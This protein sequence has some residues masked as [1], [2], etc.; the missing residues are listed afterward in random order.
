MPSRP[1]TPLPRILVVDDEE[2]MRAVMELR[3]GEW[4]FEVHTAV[5]GADAER[6]VKR[7]RPDLVISDVIMPDMTGQE[8]MRSLLAGD[9]DCPVLLMTAHGTVEMA[10]EAMKAGAHDF[11]TKPLDY[12]RLRATL[13]SAR[14]D[15]GARRDAKRLDARRPDGSGFREFVGDD[16]S[17]RQVYE[18][19]REVAPTEATVLVTGESGTGKELTARAIRQLSRRAA[20]PFVAINAAAIPDELVE[21]EIFGHEKGAFTGAARLRRGCFELADGGTLLLDEIAEMPLALQPKLLRVLEDGRVRRIGAPREI[22]VDA[23]IIAATN[24]DPRQ[25]VSEGGLREDLFYRL[26]VFAI[27]LPPLRA[28]RGDLPLLAEHFIEACN[29]RHGTRVEGIDEE[30]LARLAGYDWPG[31]VRELR[32]AVERAVVLAKRG[33]IAARHL[34]S[35]LDERPPQRGGREVVLPV[36]TTVA[37]AERALI[38]RTLEETGQNKAEA[39]RRLG[40]DVKTIRNKLRSY[41]RTG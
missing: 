39:A 1:T 13:E 31:N 36:G 23:R 27:E 4:G 30:A 29:E 35:Y 22:E 5:D 18:L 15:L 6:Q 26:N 34:P 11:L 33:P 21:S 8:L 32:N 12:E 40:V 38:L 28:R 2:A 3:L 41:G 19:I 20:G 14:V 24:R 17:M 25:L 10:V 9:A 7:I 37:E 16:P